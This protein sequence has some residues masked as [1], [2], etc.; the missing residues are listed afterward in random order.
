ML[1]TPKATAATV[2]KTPFDGTMVNQQATGIVAGLYMG[3][4]HFI[5]YRQDRNNGKFEIH[6]E[7]GFS[8]TDPALIDMVCGWLE[9]HDIAHAIIQV[10]NSHTLR[11]S[12]HSQMIKLIDILEPYMFG[13]KLHEARLVRR[14]AAKRILLGSGKGSH[15][16]NNA[17]KYDDGDLMLCAEKLRLKE[18]SEATR[19]SHCWSTHQYR[20]R[21]DMVHA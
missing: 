8:N 11:V 15:S 3:E 5:L 6:A 14:Y 2:A 4:G 1:E 18:S 20:Q 7:A 19:S 13:Q 9:A 12:R 10:S 21:E 17:R 16:G